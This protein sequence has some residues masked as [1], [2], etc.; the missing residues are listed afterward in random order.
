MLGQMMSFLHPKTSN[1]F[2]S[3]LEEKPPSL[4]WPTK[5]IHDVAPLPLLGAQPEGSCLGASAL[6]LFLGSSS[7]DTGLSSSLSSLRSLLKCQLFSD[8]FP[9]H[10]TENGTH[11]V[12]SIPFPCLIFLHGGCHHPTHY[13][14]VLI[15]HFIIY[16]LQ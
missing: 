13:I 8:V 14:W 6:L 12:Y 2:P 16:L 1:G 11:T 7:P 10:P 9:D 15:S 5:P 4:Q 3:H